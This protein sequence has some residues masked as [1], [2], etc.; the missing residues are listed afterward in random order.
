MN[1]PKTRN[2][3]IVVQEMDNEILIYDLKTDKAFCLNETSALIYQLCDG[4]RN[5]PEINRQLNKH[6]NESVSEELI[7]LALDNFK[8]ENLLEENEK[9]EI[10]FNGLNRRQIIKK[11]GLASLIAL[12]MVSSVVAP[13][14]ANAASGLG[15]LFAPCVSSPDCDPSARF[16]RTI[17]MGAGA[18][19]MQCCANGSSGSGAVVS[20]VQTSCAVCFER[21]AFACCSNTGTPGTCTETAPGSGDFLCDVTCL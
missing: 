11:I 4:K 8:K 13:S 20:S 2:E 15:L 1:K 3:N 21:A 14:A 19:T 5:I 18:G 16:C 17:T 6:L 10:D 12:P 7:W 9:F